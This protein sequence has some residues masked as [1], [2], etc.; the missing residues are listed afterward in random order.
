MGGT[1]VTTCGVVIS[2]ELWSSINVRLKQSV[3]H[4]IRLLLGTWVYT[5]ILLSWSPQLGSVKLYSM[6][7]RRRVDLTDFILSLLCVC[8]FSVSRSSQ[9]QPVKDF[10]CSQSLSSYRLK[11]KCMGLLARLKNPL[12][13]RQAWWY[14]RR[15]M[16]RCEFVQTIVISIKWLRGN[17]SFAE[18]IRARRKSID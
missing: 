15:R 16:E 5:T 12:L 7:L 17:D 3:W 1:S 9:L 4:T 11:H 13:G 2:T 14:C 18:G 6:Y 8:L 10:N